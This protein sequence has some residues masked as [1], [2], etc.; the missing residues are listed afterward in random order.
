[1]AEIGRIRYNSSDMTKKLC[2]NRLIGSERRTKLSITSHIQN[3]KQ[4]H[5]KLSSEVEQAYKSPASDELYIS[6]LKKEKL[7]LKEEIS[8]L[9]R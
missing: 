5:E 8:R 4:K 3:L 6:Q 2:S 9:S 1:M 7:R